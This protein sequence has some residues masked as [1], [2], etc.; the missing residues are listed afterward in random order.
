MTINLVNQT[1]LLL[2]ADGVEA[3]ETLN[4]CSYFNQLGAQVTIATPYNYITVETVSGHSRGADILVDLPLSEIVPEDYQCLIVPSGLLAADLLKRE[5]SVAKLLDWFIQTG[6]LIM[7]SGEAEELLGADA[8]LQNHA[9]FRSNLELKSWLELGAIWL[10][11]GEKVRS[12][13][14]PPFKLVSPAL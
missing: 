13:L 6:R 2:L 1:V 11:S 14:I 4:I 10:D 9:L 12:A 5:A 7:L 3:E 8:D